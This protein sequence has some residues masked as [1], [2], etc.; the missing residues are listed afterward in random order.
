MN[1]INNKKKIMLVL[2]IALMLTMVVC[3][4]AFTFAKYVSSQTTGNQQANTAQWGFTISADAT[5]LFGTDYT[6]EGGAAATVVETGNGVA[7]KAEGDNNLVAPGTT[8]S[9]TL[10]L[11]GKSEVLA[12]VSFVASSDVKDIYVN[13]YYPVK[14]TVTE[15]GGSIYAGNKLSDALDCIK[16]SISELGTNGVIA[17]GTDLSKTYTLTWVWDFEGADTNHQQDT[18]LGLLAGC[19]TVEEINGIYGANMVT[20]GKYNLSMLF[21]FTVTIEQLQSAS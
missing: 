11:S 19:K 18:L 1:S 3:M 21:G 12:K 10:A 9:L 2:S 20:A 17:P 8:G 15:S 14:W 16:T 13:D 4:G 5:K 6:L 7:V